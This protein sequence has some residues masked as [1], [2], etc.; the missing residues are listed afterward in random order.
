MAF[1]I[2]DLMVHVLPGSG[3]GDGPAECDASDLQSQTR[4]IGLPPQLDCRGGASDPTSPPPQLLGCGHTCLVTYGT[5]PPNA[6]QTFDFRTSCG[7][8]DWPIGGGPGGGGSSDALLVL[9]NQLAEQLKKVDAQ[10]AASQESLKPQTVEQVD[11]LTSKLNDALEELKQRREQL[12]KAK[13][14]PGSAK[15]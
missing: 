4:K 13:G 6:Q 9:R 12:A 2:R 3:A 11:M 5:P 14:A 15:P 7:A 8:T 1:K 10:Y